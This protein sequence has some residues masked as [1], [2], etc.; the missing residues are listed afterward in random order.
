MAQGVSHGRLAYPLFAGGG[1]TQSIVAWLWAIHELGL[2]HISIAVCAS[3][4]EALCDLKRDFIRNG[5]PKHKIGLIHSYQYRPEMAKSFLNGDGE[6]RP[7]FA[8]EPSTNENDDKPFLLCT[9]N[10]VK[11]RGGID[12][13]NLYKDQPRSLLLWDESLLQSESR[14]IRKD[15]LQSALGWF[16]PLNNDVN[17]TRKKAVEFA[18]TAIEQINAELRNQKDNDAEPEIINLPKLSHEEIREYKAV[19]GTNDIVSPIRELLEVSLNDLRVIGT[20][21]QSG[22]ILQYEIM[23][24]DELKNIIILDAS[25]KI[26][27]LS[28]LDKTIRMLTGIR[29]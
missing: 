3:K 14:G 12:R 13:F 18:K 29:K 16:V 26:R 19:F 24:P 28:L 17:G 20:G 8:S 5:I 4:V 23:V 6:L 2:D 10:L 7:N 25:H 11:G 15:L 1:K 22:G 27:E 9:H 21:I